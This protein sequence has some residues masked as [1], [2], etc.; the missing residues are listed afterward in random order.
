MVQSECHLR[1]NA[2]VATIRAAVAV[3]IVRLTPH[4]DQTTWIDDGPNRMAEGRGATADAQ[5]IGL[6][7]ARTRNGTV[8]V[9]AVGN[10]TNLAARQRRTEGRIPLRVVTDL[11]TDPRIAMGKEDKSVGVTGLIVIDKSRIVAK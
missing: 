11:V 8:S 10:G 9:V 4:H 3:T 5:A 7:V 2:W 1:N 6:D